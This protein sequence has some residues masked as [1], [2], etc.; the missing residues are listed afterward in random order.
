[1]R[2]MSS[3]FRGA[4][5][6]GALCLAF[7][8]VTPASAAE[9]DLEAPQNVR[10]THDQTR[11]WETITWNA[12]SSA[13]RYEIWGKVQVPGPVGINFIIG[14]ASAAG[15][16]ANAGSVYSGYSYYG[17]FNT[18]LSKWTLLGTTSS[19]SYQF[20]YQ[21][22][23]SYMAYTEYAE[24][25]PYGCYRVVAISNTTPTNGAEGPFTRGLPSAEVHPALGT[26]DL[27]PANNPY[28]KNDNASSQVILKWSPVTNATHYE[29]WRKRQRGYVSQQSAAGMPYLEWAFDNSTAGLR[30]YA[31]YNAYHAYTAIPNYT[32]FQFVAVT[33]NNSLVLNVLEMAGLGGYH[34]YSGYSIYSTYIPYGVYKIVAIK[35][36]SADRSPASSEAIYDA[37]APAEPVGSSSS[38]CFL[39]SA[40]RE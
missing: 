33:A 32:D 29:I 40:R 31:D 25:S 4:V 17:A 8:V 26:T 7:A 10:M 20:T 15:A 11:L 30:P 36:G 22:Y 16:G 18:R 1:M 37:M 12:V 28:W 5:L 13:N 9:K 24:Y 39:S 19:L 23:L 3:M 6:V 21:S 38:G 27:H 34:E 14:P 2:V 35:M